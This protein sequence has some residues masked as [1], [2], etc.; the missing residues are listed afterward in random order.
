MLLA[1]AAAAQRWIPMPRW[2]A[3]IGRP[4]A[5]P[6]AWKGQRIEV[7][8]LRWASASERKVVRA[9]EAAGRHLPWEPKCLAEAMVGQLLLRQFGTPGVVVV[10]LRQG[11][12]G[13][14]DAHAWLLGEHGAL[15]GGRAAR[16]FTATTV[17]GVSGGLRADDVELGAPPAPAG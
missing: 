1:L 3:L 4:T 6:A 7:V 2:S 10:G 11:D 16:G 13:A 5:V 9:V 14:W 12:D 17:F 15:T 8:P